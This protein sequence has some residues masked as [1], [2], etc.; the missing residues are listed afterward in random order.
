[1]S[2]IVISTGGTIA[3]TKGSGGGASP[4]LTGDDLVTNVPGLSDDIE[5]TTYDFSNIPSPHFSVNQMHKLSELIADYDRDDTVDGI[6]ITQGTDTLEEVAY[7]V[8][9]CYDGDTPVVFTGAMRNPSLASPDGPANLLI[10]IR[11]AT[12]DGARGRG[13]LVAFNDQVHAAKLVTKTHS[14]RLDT[15]RS[16]EL[17]P[18]AVHDEETIRWR[19]S[20]DSTPTID[21]AP[22]TLTNEVAALTVTVDMPPSQIPEPDDFESVVLATTG[23]GHIP[24][25]IISPLEELAREDVPLVATTRCL[26]GRLATS[27]YNYRGS[28]Q[29]LVGLG[30]YFSDRNLQKTR[31]A[32]IVALAGRSLETMFDRP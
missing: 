8:D 22:E 7:F 18:L 10:A 26:E 23:A 16:P 31:I 1:M 4:E 12:S 15:F 3:S 21:I 2:V 32:T 11:T 25:G 17:G 5:L 29:T 30:C 20:V 13:V 19:A 14:M 6:V 28:E 24:T 27:T 9:L